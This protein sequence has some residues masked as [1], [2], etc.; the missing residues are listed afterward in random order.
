MVDL[1]VQLPLTADQEARLVQLQ[2]VFSDACNL[3]SPMV[4]ETRCWNRV[5]LHHMVYRKLREGF[6]ALG[7]QMCC[8]VVY[9]VCRA[10][11]AV[12]QGADSPWAFNSGA[13]VLPLIRFRETAPVYFDR[14]TLSLRGSLLSLFTLDG[15]MRVSVDLQSEFV[16]RFQA[17]DLREISLLRSSAGFQLLFGFNREGDGSDRSSLPGHLII[18]DPAIAML[19]EHRSEESSDAHVGRIATR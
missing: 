19:E 1:V 10:A 5:A 3:V 2:R 11:R 6:P 9:S 13:G 16:E 17:G 7:S 12:Y 15:R 14:H 18:E 4:R 8:N